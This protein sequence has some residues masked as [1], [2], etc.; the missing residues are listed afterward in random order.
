MKKHSLLI[1]SILLL[2]VS[3][4]A[5]WYSDYLFNRLSL[6]IFPICLILMTSFFALLVLSIRR[7]IK[8]KEHSCFIVIVVLVLTAILVVFFPFRDARVKH[9]LS[10]FESDRLEIVEMIKN[11][12]LQP[13][14]G[15]GNAVL[16]VRYRR[17]SSDGEV[18][19]YQ[20]DENGQVI[21][22]WIFRGTLSGSVELVYSTGGEELI[23]AN[24]SGHAITKIE[25][26][27]E[28]WYYVG[29]DY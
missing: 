25:R 27:K 3:F 2:L 23:R 11:D 9:E 7:I 26:L 29:T 16:P 10:R 19:I 12:Q 18:F 21:G 17:L 28:Y 8:Q 22:F 24:E 6:L 14:D 13:K 15:I 4:V 20:N 5:A 1:P